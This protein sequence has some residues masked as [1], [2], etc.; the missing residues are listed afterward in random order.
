MRQGDLF[1]AFEPAIDESFG[2]AERTELD[3]TSWIEHVPGWLRGGGGLFDDLMASAPW[4]QRYRYIRTLGQVIEPRLS[5]EYK[6]IS[7]APPGMLHTI[8]TALARHYEVAYRYLWLNLYR[9]NRDSTSW[10]GDPIGR[11]QPTSVVPVL[12]L[13]E[14]RRFLIKP[15]EG[16]T[17]LSLAVASGDLVVMGGRCQIDWRHAVPKQATAAGPRISVNFAPHYTGSGREER[18]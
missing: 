3:S 16:G 10:H 15:V 17:S 4:E 13:G 18:P 2:T 8:T 14:T 7:A 9:T 1:E 11:Y 6:D 5:A 12:S